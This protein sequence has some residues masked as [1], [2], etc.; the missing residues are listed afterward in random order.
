MKTKALLTLGLLLGLG[1]C[2]GGSSATDASTDNSNSSGE[3][4]QTYAN[5]TLA[6]EVSFSNVSVHDPSIV[7]DD[8]GTYY[9]FGSHLAE[10]KSS[11]LMN[12]T[13]LATDVTDDNP[14]FDT[15]SSQVAEG[16]A[17][18]GGHVG[19]WA[20]D[21]I[22]LADGRYYFYYDFCGSVDSGDCDSSRSYIGV[23][24]SDSIEGPYQN[25]G[26]IL[27]TGMTA[28]E[29]TGADGQV[30]NGNLDPNAIDPD[31]F[32]DKDGQLWMVYGSYSGGIWILKMDDSTGFPVAGQGYGTHLTGGYFSAI[33]GPNILYNADTGYY[34]LFTSFGGY[35]QNDGYNL[36]VSRS[37][38]PDGPY[39]DVEGN[40]MI[41]AS[42]S[43]SAIAPYGEKIMA[44]NLFKA[45]AGDPGSDHGYMS[46]GHNSTYYDAATGHYY[47]VMHTRFLDSGEYHEVRVHQL[48]FN[49]DGWPVAAPLRY[50]PLDGDNIV[51]AVDV[52][53]DYQFIDLGKDINTSAKASGYLSLA[54]EGVIG[55][56]YSGS[57]SLGDDNQITLTIDNLGT[58]KGV[59]S[60]QYNDN[61][62]Q[63]VPTFSAVGEDGANVW[64]SQLPA[65]TTTEVLQSIA[66][67]LSY[68]NQTS[69]SLTLPT[70]G[71][72]GATI[73]WQ[74][75]NSAVIASDGT[76]TRPNV[77]EGDQTV[78]LTA[79]ITLNGQTQTVTFTIRV[80]A[81]H[82]Y[83]RSA[84]YSFD[85]D[86]SDRLGLHGAGSATGATPDSSDGTVQFAS[87]L[88]G[89]ALW[90]DGS[91]G[92]RLPDGLIDSNQY[93][94]SLWL[95][96]A[97][98][99]QYSTA[100]FGA[101]AT[102]N[103]LSLVPWS[104]DGNTMLWSGSQSWYDASAGR[105]IATDSWS[106]LAF[107]VDHGHV[108]VFL[109]GSAVYSGSDF[110]DLFTGQ[111][112]VFTL[113]VNYWDAPYNGL[114]D[115]LK[116]YDAALSGEE[117]TALDID[118]DS[119]SELL[120]LAA[121]K[122]DVG[123]TSAVK[124]SLS[125]PTTGEFASAISWQSSN[126]AVL[127]NDGTVTQPSASQGDTTVTL[128]A[129][130]S[131][132]GLS[133]SKA[134]AVT[135]RSL[136]APTPV[137][138]YDFDNDDLTDSQGNFA[139]GTVVGAT[140]GSSGGSVSYA[141]GVVG[142]ALVLDGSSGVALPNN[143]ITDNS[144]SVSLWLK[145]S[146]LTQYSSAFFA[147]ASSASWI[148]LVP[149][150]VDG[151]SKHSMLWSG[152]AWYD[153]D[154]GEQ[155]PTDSWSQLAFVVNNGSVA[156][157]LNGV[158]AFTGSGYPDIFSG[159]D[160]TGFALGVNFWDIP[161]HGLVDEVKIFNDALSDSDVLS[162]YQQGQN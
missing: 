130:L 92:V 139:A 54:A 79:T 105:Q 149:M 24:V 65:A 147:Y 109:N 141:S 6:G 5:P 80:P 33:E 98:L 60:W 9:I 93:T 142:Q 116:V 104:W 129:T 123:D 28:A 125:L 11:D 16:I 1:G 22:K 108:T 148:S 95:D 73:S 155:I 58:F 70:L 135:V 82:Q 146:A 76:V 48:L 3:T 34:Y 106:H 78:T 156:V 124:A 26:L 152:E 10:A 119:S 157:Y 41:A 81:R 160:P 37:R 88:T 68:A 150:G 99:S 18:T 43:W 115:E 57:Y 158:L 55:G 66:N 151:V 63:L 87:G 23:A 97:A 20:P 15:Y 161:Y 75:S 59:L 100:F 74:S 29:G 112:G 14:L 44:G 102:D 52:Q 38:E 89:N 69:A 103:W 144:Y 49:A 42:G 101:Q 159:V 30:Y 122:L 162:L 27:K 110:P 12:W 96:P 51:D 47:L 67:S 137:A 39:L 84:W 131:L 31:V 128:T 121:A 90:L 53:G 154:M 85:S 134:F 138:E 117:I 4:V 91:A 107:A 113:G 13:L 127:A 153:T 45:N 56:Q 143:L 64:G 86:L 7:R 35:A 120:A 32:Y 17:W 46:P 77:G 118:H 50:V 114:I 111:S 145:P 140:L 62:G 133:T 72:R 126:S 61:I 8:A 25:L 2:G 83:N 132:D 136:G 19:S 40:D 71:S 21:V 94:V 36:R